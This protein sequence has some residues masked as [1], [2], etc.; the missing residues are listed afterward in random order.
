MATPLISRYISE[1]VAPKLFKKTTLKIFAKIKSLICS[2][3]KKETPANMFSYE[4][5][6][7]SHIE[8]SFIE[9]LPAAI[10]VVFITENSTNAV[11]LNKFSKFDKL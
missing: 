10:F 9:H 8:I 11:K 7:I 2:F 1:T 4:F 5:C 6:E 3:L